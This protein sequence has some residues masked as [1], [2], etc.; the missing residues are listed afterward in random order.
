MVMANNDNATIHGVSQSYLLNLL[1]HIHGAIDGLMA[2]LDADAGT[3]LSTDYQ[4]AMQ[5]SLP[6][7]AAPVD[8]ILTAAAVSTLVEE[9]SA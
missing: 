7:G 1:I 4:A 5:D 2:K 8:G 3:A 9:Y 6:I